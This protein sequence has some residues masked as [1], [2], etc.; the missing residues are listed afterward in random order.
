MTIKEVLSEYQFRNVGQF[1]G[2]AQSLG[3]SE[4]YNKGDLLFTRG[5]DEYRTTI[6][7]VRGC[8]KKVDTMLMD[9]SM[10]RI[11]AFFDRDQAL[12]ESYRKT[13]E[14]EGV[15]IVNWGDLKSDA[16]DRFTV[17]DHQNK[18]CY[19]GKELYDYAL[20]NGYLLNGQGTKLEKGVLSELTKVKGKPAKIRLTDNGTSIYYRKEA[21]V[22]P[23]SLLGKKLSKKQQ[24]DLLDG[25]VIVLST[26]K[27]SVF[28]QV[29]RDLNSV[30][31]RSE[32][33]LAVPAQI[34]GYKLTT[35]DKYLMANGYSLE[36]KLMKTPQGYI[37]ADVSMTPDKKGFAFSNTQMVSETKAKELLQK[38]I[39][40]SKRDFE[41]EFKEAVS[42]KNYE[43]LSQLKEDGYKPSEE[44]IKGLGKDSAVDEKQ[45]IVIE[46]LFG[47]KPEVQ[48]SADKVTQENKEVTPHPEKLPE[49]YIIKL[50]KPV[51]LGDYINSLERSGIDVS[52]L[53]ESFPSEDA[54]NEKLDAFFVMV[55]NGKVTD[56]ETNVHEN[57]YDIPIKLFSDI[58]IDKNG[59]GI[60]APSANEFKAAL[61]TDNYEKIAQL[62]DH[63]YQLS[64]TDKQYLSEI[65]ENKAIAVRKIFGLKTSG[66]VL[67]DVKL[68]Q[69]KPEKDLTRPL[70]STLNRAFS[71]L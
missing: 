18:I 7:A 52:V 51:L 29:D 35:A 11:C 68:A 33:E 46:K 13:L 16:K 26:K 59:K 3:Y 40:D 5:D 63:G 49:N 41:A 67:G 34:G 38:R 54:K 37:I 55:D 70:T 47:M 36:N 50:D 60:P 71:D 65:P 39:D 66:N 58:E 12:S 10:E 53:H 45:A 69:G 64:E 6:A 48:Q 28:L 32:K 30:V 15:D 22:I 2:I 44:V 14:K 42:N 23:D 43:K 8:T 27:G 61:E 25:N 21:L 9:S 31:V 19:T 4:E 17:I 62:K 20:E 56:W 1:R 57:E 24:Q